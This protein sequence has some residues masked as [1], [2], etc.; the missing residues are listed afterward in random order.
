MLKGLSTFEV[1]NQ[2][3]KKFFVKIIY[4]PKA[5]NFIES[6]MALQS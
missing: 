3:K 4:R 2:T 1:L 6:K 5:N